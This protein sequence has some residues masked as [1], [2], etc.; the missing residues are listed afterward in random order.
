MSASTATASA[1]ASSLPADS[2]RPGRLR[3]LSQLR[4]YTQNHLSSSSSSSPSSSVNSPRSYFANRVS[5]LSPSSPPAARPD[6]TTPASCAE[7]DHRHHHQHRAARAASTSAAPASPQRHCRQV[8]D[9]TEGGTSPESSSGVARSDDSDNQASRSSQSS[10]AARPLQSPESAMASDTPTPITP[11]PS[12]AVAATPVANAVPDL[13]G[14]VA[15]L[16]QSATQTPGR[17]QQ[18][19]IKFHPYQDFN[20]QSGRPSLPF[21]P[22]TRT[23]PSASCVIRVGRYSERDGVPVANPTAPSDAPVGFKSK[24]VSRKHCEFHFLHGQ[25]HIRDVG[26]SSGTFLNHMRLSQ[27]NMASRLY[28]IKDGDIVQLGIDFRGGEE[29]IFRCVR[30]RIECNRSWQQQSNEFK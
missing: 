17:K 11:E 21:T 16:D 27:P 12:T 22:V 1:P 26:S 10:S 3:R 25:W 7:S 15:T 2:P 13:S 23:L 19:T 29:M 20:Q 28:A 8:A 18:A 14:P 4:A 9:T 30:I 5:W 6:S 24:V